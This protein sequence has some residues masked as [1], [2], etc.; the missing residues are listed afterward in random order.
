MEREQAYLTAMRDHLRSIGCKFPVTGV[1]GGD[2]LP[3]LASVADTCDFLSDNWYGEYEH[4][5]RRTPDVRY[6]TGRNPLT[7]D[8]RYGFAP[9][10]AMLK[11]NHKPVVLREWA[12]SW[13]NP[14]RAALVPEALAYAGFQDI[15]AMLLFG[16]QTVRAP[17]GTEA[18]ALNDYSFQSDP[19]V[20]GLYGLA[21]QAYL[22][23]AVK[24]AQHTLNL[25]YPLS[26]LT[27]WPNQTTELY[28]A[29]WSG[30]LESRTV[31]DLSESG[32]VPGDVHDLRPLLNF[33]QQ[34]NRQDA[35]TPAHSPG[36]GV[37]TSDTDEITRYCPEGRLE[38]R[39]PRL[40]LLAGALSPDTV[41]ELGSFRFSTPTRFGALL[42]YSLDGLPL[43]TSR[44][45]AAK[46]VSL[47]ENTGQSY[48]R[49]ATGSI[50]DFA[51]NISGKAPVLTLGK[52]SDKP[53]QLWRGAK[54][55]SFPLLTLALENGTWEALLT[56]DRLTLACDTP[57]VEGAVQGKAF[58]T[59]A[60]IVEIPLTTRASFR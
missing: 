60:Q 3:D 44:R 21:G 38:V 25:Q 41:Y 12:I 15:D 28:R 42:L 56:N 52:K 33:L 27:Q 54:N 11:W 50:A 13:P 10:A 36:S 17:N 7:D 24:P 55:Q 22:S 20:W 57:D 4:F 39:T 8:G 59:T 46:F 58:K 32:T 5:D 49:A 30:S 9:A 18:D 29:A 19:T 16:Y 31:T 1:F 53:T 6:Y 14:Y 34:L 35:L 51:L 26:R 2:I 23:G 37:W 47:A 45:L 48:V 43:E 40:C